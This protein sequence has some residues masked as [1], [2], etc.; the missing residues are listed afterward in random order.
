MEHGNEKNMIILSLIYVKS[1]N[2]MKR[3]GFRK[4]RDQKIKKSINISGIHTLFDCT[5]FILKFLKAFKITVDIVDFPIKR[6]K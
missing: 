5:Y 4:V 1:E 2:E 6:Q 3:E